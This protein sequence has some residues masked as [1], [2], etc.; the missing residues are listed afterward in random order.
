M[1]AAEHGRTTLLLQ[2]DAVVMRGTAEEVDARRMPADKLP[3]R[4]RDAARLSMTAPHKQ[5][6]T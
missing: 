6:C 5:G 1:P 4:C 3:D 2:A